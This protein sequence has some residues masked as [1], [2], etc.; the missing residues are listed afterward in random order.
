MYSRIR[1]LGWNGESCFSPS[2]LALMLSTFVPCTSWT[3][4]LRAQLVFHFRW[5]SQLHAGILKCQAISCSLKRSFLFKSLKMGIE[6]DT[7]VHPS[8]AL[9]RKR[10]GRKSRWKLW[11][12]GKRRKKNSEKEDRN[13]IYMLQKVYISWASNPSWALFKPIFGDIQP[14]W[15]KSIMLL[16]HKFYAFCTCF[17]TLYSQ[18]ESASI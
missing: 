9:G 17:V 2:I 4:M 1:H 7:P 18:K 6:K 16:Q 14:L 5:D 13:P 10:R 8:L 15:Q 12:G 3:L 11:W